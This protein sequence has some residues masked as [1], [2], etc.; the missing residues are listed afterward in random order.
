MDTPERVLLKEHYLVLEE[1]A[2][3]HN[4]E[5]ALEALKKIGNDFGIDTVRRYS[6]VVP[7]ENR[8]YWY[9]TT[10]GLGPGTIPKNITVL[11]SREGRNDKGTLGDYMCLDAVLN[12]SELKEYDLRELEPIEEKDD[13]E[14]G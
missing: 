9:F 5:S 13:Y 2:K 4:N 12:T 10:H 11:E 6:D 8:K 7:Y 14:R 1:Y 3:R